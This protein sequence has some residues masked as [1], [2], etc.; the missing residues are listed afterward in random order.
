VISMDFIRS[1]R[2]SC[3]LAKKILEFAGSLVK[4]GVTTDEIDAKVHDAIIDSGAYPSPLNYM[5][6]AKSICT[7]VNEVLG[8]GIPDSRPLV[9]G[10]II[11]IDITVFYK[12]FHGDTCA[13]FFVGEM[14]DEK[15]K[16]LVKVARKCLETGISILRPGVPIAA[17]GA[18]IQ[19]EAMRHK[20]AV[21]QHLA[22]HG[23]G[24]LFHQRPYIL[25]CRNDLR[26]ILEPGM[27]FTIEP[28]VVE[29]GV[30]VVTWDDKWTMATKDGGWSAQFE[31]T[32]LITD[33]GAEI[34]T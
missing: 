2:E 18:A 17:I 5:G 11:S 25:H 19:N 13:T 29:K 22:G 6:F 16:K 23:I 3:A 20:L 1:M 24:R 26:G 14:V 8:H 31:H 21:V 12:G 33:T 27:T 7:S 4:P 30:N 15:A 34:L 28:I 10:D 9:D 32:V